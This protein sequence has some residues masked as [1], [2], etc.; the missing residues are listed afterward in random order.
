LQALEQ[1][2]RAAEVDWKPLLDW[3]L[4][5]FDPADEDYHLHS[6]TA[7]YAQDLLDAI[8]RVTTQIEIAEWYLRYGGEESHNLTD[9]LEAHRLLRTAG[10]VERAGEL[11]MDLG[12]VLSRFGLYQLWSQL[13]RATIDD[14]Q[15]IHESLVAQA[16]HQLGNIAYQQGEYQAAV[17]YNAQALTIFEGLHSPSRDIALR[18]LSKLSAE[19]GESE[20]ALLWQNSMHGQPVPELPVV[21]SAS[22]YQQSMRD[23][24]LLVRPLGYSFP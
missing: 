17:Q 9:S 23:T 2:L 15:G 16:Q 10:E 7:H 24:I 18:E 12:E 13:C 11:A 5:R 1:G 21:A 8:D 20:F 4:L 22:R 14:A 6:L 3:A 19:L